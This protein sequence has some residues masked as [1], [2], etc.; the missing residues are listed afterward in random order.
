MHKWKEN[1]LGF[2][3][4]RIY[5]GGKVKGAPFVTCHL[6]TLAMLDLK[7]IEHEY[8]SEIIGNL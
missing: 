1:S 4:I 3:S 5:S 2:A 6:E 8:Y 7:P